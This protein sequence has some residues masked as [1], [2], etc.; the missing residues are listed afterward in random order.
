MITAISLDEQGRA[1][2]GGLSTDTKPGPSNGHVF[3]EFDTHRVFTANG[4]L[5]TER[6]NPGYQTAGASGSDPWTYVTLASDFPTSSATAV[7]VTNFFFTPVANTTY[8]FEG[9]VLLR[10]ATASVNPRFGVGWPSGMTDGVAQIMQTQTA[11][12]AP[13]SAGGSFNASI[14]TPVGGVPNTTQSFPAQVRGMLI[15]GANPSGNLRMQLA[16]ETAGTT[17]TMRAGS[18]IKHRTI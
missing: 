14:L 12:G 3:F 7:D 15:V 9:I 11:A 16:S 18:Y 4:T 5:W 8:E 17:V 13:V 10:T 1:I 6:L 2:Y